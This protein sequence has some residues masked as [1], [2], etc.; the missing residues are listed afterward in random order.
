MGDFGQVRLV[1]RVKTGASDVENPNRS[2]V[3]H[4]TRQQTK[5]SKKDTEE[6]QDANVASSDEDEPVNQDVDDGNNQRKAGEGRKVVVSNFEISTMISIF[7]SFPET[8]KR[9]RSTL[10]YPVPFT[11]LTLVHYLC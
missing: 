9:P 7:S 10:L 5:M 8:S 3:P 4:Q 2:D 1:K 6:D 11:S